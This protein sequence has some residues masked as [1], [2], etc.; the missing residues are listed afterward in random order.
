MT[1]REEIHKGEIDAFSLVHKNVAYFLC[2]IAI[3]FPN[4]YLIG[5]AL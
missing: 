3:K 1:M 2:V 5:D 4:F